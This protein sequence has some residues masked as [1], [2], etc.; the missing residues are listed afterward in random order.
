MLGRE[1]AGRVVSILHDDTNIMF[2]DDDG[3]EII[4]HLIPPKGTKY[5]GSG[6][7]QGSM[8]RCANQAAESEVSTKSSDI[9]SPR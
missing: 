3:T 7:P 8:S 9:K 5:V 2:F 1:Y 4:S 6:Q